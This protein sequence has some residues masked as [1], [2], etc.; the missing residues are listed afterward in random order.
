MICVYLFTIFIIL[1][2]AVL[3][4]QKEPASLQ[5][6]AKVEQAQSLNEKDSQENLV[7]ENFPSL[8]KAP[9]T[10]SIEAKKVS[11]PPPLKV[12]PSPESPPAGG[13]T[14]S[15]IIRENNLQREENVHYDKVRILAGGRQL[16]P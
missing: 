2:G 12:I 14:D 3:V 13:L 9:E 8:P 1:L 4:Y 7:S 5:E 16:A 10:K 6:E 11:T 15:G